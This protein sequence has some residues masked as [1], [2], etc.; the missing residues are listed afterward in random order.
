MK[1]EVINPNVPS[2]II[3]EVRDL[4]E[5]LSNDVCANCTCND[6]ELCMLCNLENE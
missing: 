3:N 4:E 5:N 2:E 6:P 1:K